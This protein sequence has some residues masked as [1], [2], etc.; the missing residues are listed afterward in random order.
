MASLPLLSLGFMIASQ[1]AL[2]DGPV[3]PAQFIEPL[4]GDPAR[5][6]SL[7]VLCAVYGV[8][9]ARYPAAGRRVSDDALR[10]PAGADDARA[11]PAQ[12]EIDALLA[13]PGVATGVL[14]ARRAWA[15]LL[16]VLFWHAPALVHWGGQ[17][18]GAGA[19]LQ[20]AGGLALQGR[21]PAVFAGLGRP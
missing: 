15:A 7:L 21:L 9:R 13:E 2:H 11:T 4:R 14:L 18:V 5:R 17:G 6:R 12:A 3:H 19:V 10:P 1:S 8:A 16:S 20:H